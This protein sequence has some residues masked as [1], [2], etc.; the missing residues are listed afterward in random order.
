MVAATLLINFPEE[1]WEQICSFLNFQDRFQLAMASKKSYDIV[2][3]IRSDIY[4]AVDLNDQRQSSFLVHQ[5]EHL[6]ISNP[7]VYFHD[8]Y[9]VLTQFRFVNHL[10]LFTLLDQ[11]NFN[12]GRF[13]SCID[14]TRRSYKITVKSDYFKKLRIEVD[15]KK[16]KSVELIE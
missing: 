8:L 5:V 10:D 2:K 15:F 13:L 9:K 11:E 3:M 1:I 16:N 7:S 12:S 14:Q 4:L 6:Q